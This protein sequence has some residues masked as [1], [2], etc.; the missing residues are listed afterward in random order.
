[1]LVLDGLAIVAVDYFTKWVEAKSYSK[2]GAKQVKEFIEDHIVTR[3]GTPHSIISDN[4][5]QFQG[6]TKQFLFENGIQ[7]HK[8]SPYRPQANGQVE[9]ANKIIKKIL[10]KMT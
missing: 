7:H 4:G 2:L 5:V 8:S 10:A 9:A 3:F 6:V 1:M